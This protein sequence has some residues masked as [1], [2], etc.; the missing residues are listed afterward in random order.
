MA[1]LHEPSDSEDELPELLEILIAPKSSRGRAQSKYASPRKEQTTTNGQPVVSPRAEDAINTQKGLSSV[2]STVT[3]SIGDRQARKQKPLRLAHVNSLL[4]PTANLFSKSP[5]ILESLQQKH[6]NDGHVKD[7]RRLAATQ[8][9]D[10]STFVTDL[11]DT[12]E[13]TEE[14][15][16]FDD[17]SDFLVDDSVSEEE[18]KRPRSAARRSPKKSERNRQ[19]IQPLGDARL[20][21]G[22]KE[23]SA[24]IDLISPEKDPAVV[25]VSVKSKTS[26]KDNDE[27]TFN[28]DPCATLRL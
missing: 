24:I 19:T 14:E 20:G 13:L 27:N 4:L 16:S 2:R 3:V 28:V 12:L 18:L 26:I 1:R 6:G 17:L 5:V 9:V 8:K 21:R 22:L 25:S 7:T 10:Y 15:A 23:G 11:Q